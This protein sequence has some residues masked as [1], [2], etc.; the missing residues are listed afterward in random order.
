MANK[1]LNKLLKTS[2]QFWD[3]PVTVLIP[4]AAGAQQRR[5]GEVRAEYAQL[6]ISFLQQVEKVPQE[7]QAVLPLFKNFEDKKIQCPQLYLNHPFEENLD[8]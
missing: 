2:A 1:I 8:D 6:G 3:S 4:G 5:L 7:P